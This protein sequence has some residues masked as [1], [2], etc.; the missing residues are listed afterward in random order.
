MIVCIVSDYELE[1][2]GEDVSAGADS[3]PP[4]YAGV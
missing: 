3:G 2:G 1:D 4:V